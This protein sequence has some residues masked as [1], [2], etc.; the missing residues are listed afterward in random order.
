MANF[1]LIFLSKDNRMQKFFVIFL[2]IR[3]CIG[4][5]EEL[6]GNGNFRPEDKVRFSRTFSL[7]F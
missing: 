4:S 6:F 2:F 1:S 7:H 5:Y 3:F